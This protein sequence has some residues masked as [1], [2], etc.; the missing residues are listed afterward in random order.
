MF[1]LLLSL[2]VQL[3]TP[4]SPESLRGQVQEQHQ[5]P[6][7]A[8]QQVQEQHQLP[9]KLTAK[10]GFCVWGEKR[11]IGIEGTVW[12]LRCWCTSQAVRTDQLTSGIRSS[13]SLCNSWGL[14]FQSHEQVSSILGLFKKP[15]LTSC[16]VHLECISTEWKTIKTTSALWGKYLGNY[17]KLISEHSVNYVN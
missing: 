14:H 15:S 6:R 1:R 9:G 7:K 4:T 17:I 5:L 13:K 3:S 2:T 8:L 11:G 12:T 16:Q 10:R